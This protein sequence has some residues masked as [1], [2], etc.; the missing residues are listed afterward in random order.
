[1]T[2]SDLE[3]FGP[4]AAALGAEGS[5]G[6]PFACDDMVLSIRISLFGRIRPMKVSMTR[7]LA[8]ACLAFSLPASASAADKPFPGIV[9]FG[10][11]LSDPGNAFHIRGGINRPPE[12][13]LDDLMVPSAP[14][15]RGG[16]HLSNGAVWVVQLA[17][18]LGLAGSVQP[19]YRSSSS[20][21]T[22]YAVDRAR[23]RDDGINVN[24]PDQVDRFL[25]DFDLTA[26]SDWLYVIE[27][28]SNDVRDALFAY[29]G[30]LI[31]TGDQ[32]AAMAAAGAVIEAALTSIA[33]EIVELYMAGARHFLIANV[34]DISLTPSLTIAEATNPGAKALAQVLVGVFNMQL[35][36]VLA[37]MTQSLGVD[38][39]RLD[40]YGRLYDIVDAPADFGLTNITDACI[41]PEIPPF[42]CRDP[43]EYLFWDGIHPTRTVHAIL[44]EL[45][46]DALAL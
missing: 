15:A 41:M 26:P 43:D 13:W 29:V 7:W 42:T 4:A 1:V 18:P 11:S 3:P 33:N 9:V 10:T 45:A 31:A 27:M 21:A 5:M 35:D 19:A 12:Y 40:L 14:Y 38:I 37:N 25:E 20:K 46:R 2:A 16:H 39:A 28:G 17:R 22:N 36:G 30:T 32:A 23:A 24:L 6:T 34:P 8:V 44:A